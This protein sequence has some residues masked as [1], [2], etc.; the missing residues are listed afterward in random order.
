MAF[1]VFIICLVWFFLMYRAYGS[2]LSRR[3]FKLDDSRKTPAHIFCDNTDYVP[4]N[5][6][7]VWGHNFTS[8]AGLGPIVGPAIGVIWGWV[9][10]LLWIT[11]GTVFFGGVHDFASLVISIRNK[12]L[13]IGEITTKV[14]GKRAKYLFMSIIFLELWVVIAIFAMIM[15]VLFKMYP[16]SVFPIWMEIPIAITLSYMVFRKGKSLELWS[17]IALVAMYAT[18]AIG[19]LVPIGIPGPNAV[20]IWIII[21]MIYAYIASTLPVETL[22]QPRDY[23]NSHELLVA[24]LMIFAGAVAAFI[25]DPGH[26]GFV[27]PAFNFSARGAPPVW[28]FLFVTIAC[29][30]ISGFHSLVASGTASKQIDRE[31]DAKLVGYGGMIAEGVLAAL[32]VLAV[33]AGFGANGKGLADGIAAWSEHYADWSSAS[34]MAANIKAFVTGASNMMSYIFGNSRYIRELMMTIMGVFIV[35]FAGTTIDTAARTQRYIVQEFGRSVGWRFLTGK[36]IATLVAV[37]SAFGLAMVKPGGQGALI[38]WPLFGTINQ[39]LA[40]LTLVVVTIYLTFKRAKPWVAAIPTGFLVVMT[41]WA[42]VMNVQ[43]YYRTHNWLL[44]GVGSV[45]FLLMCWL[46]FEAVT[47]LVRFRKNPPML[48]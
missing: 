18:V 45:V 12:G 34:G 48:D 27:A 43:Q 1:I 13:S 44:V 2:F 8:I 26:L 41:G 35:S 28:P 32:V 15:G 3:V 11:L 22:L 42:M 47:V 46:V 19:V 36:H 40:G 30:A 25:R 9:P 17:W 24:A 31:G 20:I 14:I 38:L 6:W 33:A 23:I 39:L 10:A 37:G 4:S 21:L 29:G 7:V 16:T 5:R